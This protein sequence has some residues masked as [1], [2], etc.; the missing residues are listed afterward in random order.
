M[1]DT[2]TPAVLRGPD[3]DPSPLTHRNLLS[4]AVKFSPENGVVR[5][6]SANDGDGL[7]IHCI[8]HGIGIAAPALDRLFK[9]FRQLDV[10]RRPDQ[11]SGL[12]LGFFIAKTLLERSGA[13]LTFANRAA[14]EHGAVIRVRWPR[15]V[16]DISGDRGAPARRLGSGHGE[17]A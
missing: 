9:P 12:G 14:P 13:E 15:H 4:N 10:D 7:V 17:A 8:D 6:V 5:L 3:P 1:N 16:I 11:G 2:A